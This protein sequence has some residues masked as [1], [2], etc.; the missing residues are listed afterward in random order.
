M[1]VLCADL[2]S[3]ASL[4]HDRD[5]VRTS[6]NLRQFMTD[7]KDAEA[8]RLEGRHAFKESPAFLWR[9]NLCRL[10]EDKDTGTGDELLQDFHLLLLS[11][12]QLSRS[13]IEPRP[14]PE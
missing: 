14:E 6:Q 5:P 9:E 1:S 12:G 10:V 7:E 11:R 13:R 2:P 4:S 3:N 8:A